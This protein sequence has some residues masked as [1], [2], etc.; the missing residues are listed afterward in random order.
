MAAPPSIGTRITMSCHEDIWEILEGSQQCRFR[1][2]VCLATSSIEYP[3][4]PVHV[5]EEQLEWI[6][7]IPTPFLVA[8]SEQVVKILASSKDSKKDDRKR[9]AVD[10][11]VDDQ[12]KRPKDGS[13]KES[14]FRSGAYVLR[15]YCCGG[16]HLRRNCPLRQ[17]KQQRSGVDNCYVCGKQGHR[18][19]DC[20]YAV[21]SPRHSSRRTE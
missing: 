3:M 15:C 10:S 2:R 9:K 20:R 7:P 6:L 13:P 12:G 14:S 11:V 19:R 5:I 21:K 4:H 1:G 8:D 18:S 17:Q 16:D